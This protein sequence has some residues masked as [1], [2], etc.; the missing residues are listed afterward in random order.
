MGMNQG[1]FLLGPLHYFC[2]YIPNQ[3]VASIQSPDNSIE[4]LGDALL[5]NKITFG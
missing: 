5:M 3:Q 4:I 2:I 1:Q